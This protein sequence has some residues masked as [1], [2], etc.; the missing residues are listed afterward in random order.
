[1]KID[2]DERFLKITEIFEPQLIAFHNEFHDRMMDIFD[3]MHEQYL[4]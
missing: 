1:M 2:G 3:E 4:S